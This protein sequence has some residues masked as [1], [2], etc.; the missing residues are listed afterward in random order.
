MHGVSNQLQSFNRLLYL[1]IG[2]LVAILISLISIGF[3]P[4]FIDYE[5]T[6]DSKS[7]LSDEEWVKL[8]E[9]G[10]QLITRTSFYLGPMAKNKSM[11]LAGNNLSCS[12]CHLDAGKKIGAMPFIGVIN[13]FPQ[14]RSREN[15]IGTIQERIN[16]CMER[17]M[18][19]ETLPENSKE[20]NAIIAYMTE[21]GN[22]TNDHKYKRLVNIE[23][24]ERSADP[25]KGGRLYEKHCIHC[26]G[27]EGIGTLKRNGKFQKYFYPPLAGKDSYNDGAGMNRV[28][29]AAQFIKGN[30]PLGVKHDAPV[31]KDS[32]AYD[33]AAYINSLPRPEK[34]NKEADFPDLKLKPMSTAYAPWADDFS[35]QQHKYG[36]FQPIKKF[37]ERKYGINKTK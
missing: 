26:H 22:E 31:L 13:R 10:N 30:M 2:V 32:E 29:T 20:M 6:S 11:R 12:N 34:P 37:Y 8:V 23:L 15:K 24:P 18:N 16:G 33:L 36:P 7:D 1:L 25:N 9:Y 4:N 17:S 19:G 28:I 5:N 27:K 3:A 21:I 14:F 35:P